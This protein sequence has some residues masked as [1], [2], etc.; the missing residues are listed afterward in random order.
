LAITGDSNE[1]METVYLFIE[2]A[3]E[4]GQGSEDVVELFDIIFIRTEWQQ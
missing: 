4:T 2:L 1:A 3:T